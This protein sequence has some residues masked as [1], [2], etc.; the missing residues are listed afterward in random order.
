MLQYNAHTRSQ[1]DVYKALYVDDGFRS[2]F[3][4]EC[5]VIMR[6]SADDFGFF[7]ILPEAELPDD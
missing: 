4:T 5:S 1:W 2:T 6:A 3:L 7:E